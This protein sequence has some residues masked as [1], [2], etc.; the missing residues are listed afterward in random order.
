VDK[1]HKI[2][3]AG[4]LCIDN[5]TIEGNEM[6]GWGS[7]IMY[8]AHYLYHA[9]GLVSNAFSPYGNDF[10]DYF[11]DSVKILNPATSPK[12]LQYRNIVEGGKRTQFCELPI[13]YDLPSINNKIISSLKECG[14]IIVSPMTP[15]YNAEYVSALMRHT[16]SST[17]NVLLPQGYMRNI[18]T[19]STITP[20]AFTEIDSLAQWFNLIILSE[21]DTDD[22]IPKA[23]KWTSN[24]KHLEVIVTQADKGATL[25]NSNGIQHIPTIPIPV[26]GIVN[27]VGGGDTFSASVAIEKI[28][29]NEK[30]E[31]CIRRAHISTGRVLEGLDAIA[32]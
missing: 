29:R 17:L 9:Y 24:N 3:L 21:E 19:N 8:I 2:F 11:D 7:S 4:E 10:I 20:R 13:T 16:N 1:K 23:S 14:L 6:T 28:I 30:T 12:T 27:P 15:Q 26:T 25:V 31:E 22:A 32:A 18:N 5:N